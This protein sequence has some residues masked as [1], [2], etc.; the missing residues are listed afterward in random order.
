MNFLRIATRIASGDSFAVL[1]DGSDIV[2]V[3]VGFSPSP[4]TLEQFG[5]VREDGWTFAGDDGSSDG[6]PVL[7]QPDS[8]A[9]SIISESKNRTPDGNWVY[10]PLGMDVAIWRSEQEMFD[11]SH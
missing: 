7:M 3:A 2:G 9:V 6:M 1:S 5:L 8:G 10:S 11:S 4:S